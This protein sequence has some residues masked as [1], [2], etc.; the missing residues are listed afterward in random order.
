MNHNAVIKRL[1]H[2]RRRMNDTTS[3]IVGRLVN[4]ENLSQ[5]FRKRLASIFFP[6][7]VILVED[8][9]S[10][11]EVMSDSIELVSVLTCW[12]LASVLDR[13]TELYPP[14]EGHY[15]KFYQYMRHP[16]RRCYMYI[17][18]KM[19]EGSHE[20]KEGARITTM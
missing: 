4:D 6:S 12:P 8:P 14:I 7:N 5:R 2:W 20:E 17:T 16:K 9:L 10:E 13:V 15:W 19:T 11:F 3:G 1:E 18:L